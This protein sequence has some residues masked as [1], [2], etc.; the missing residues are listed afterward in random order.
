M[1]VPMQI[2][3]PIIMIVG[4]GLLITM[5]RERYRQLGRMHRRL[6][7][8][9]RGLAW[10][11][12]GVIASPFIFIMIGPFIEWDPPVALAAWWFIAIMVMAVVNVRYRMVGDRLLV[13]H[14]WLLCPRCEYDLTQS[15]ES[16][17]CPECGRPFERDK[18]RDA[19][20]RDEPQFPWDEMLDDWRGRRRRK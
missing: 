5:G 19:W 20:V 11:A 16:G 6:L 15:G 2:W 13:R 14:E 7:R 3:F 18:L 4:L 12:M 1:R 10:L 17:R 9:E 8:R